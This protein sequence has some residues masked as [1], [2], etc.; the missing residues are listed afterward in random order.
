MTSCP[1]C[2]LALPDHAR[3]C[4]R[5]GVRL[6]GKPGREPVPVWVLVLFW[7]GVAVLLVVASGYAL[8]LVVPGLAEQGAAQEH[9]PVG[10]F[11][12]LVG[13]AALISTLFAAAQ[14]VAS[15]GLSLAR[16]WGRIM[17][18]L[19]SVAWAL[20]CVGLPV[21]LLAL[22]SIWGRRRQSQKPPPLPS[23]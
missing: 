13:V 3:F 9:M 17:A 4:A 14:L 1:A 10:D 22:N 2:G 6:A 16:P 8:A 18:T 11:R 19:V 21:T 15:I 12:A 7:V 20:T 5:C 23:T